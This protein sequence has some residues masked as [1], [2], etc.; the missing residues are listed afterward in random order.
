MSNNLLANIR[1]SAN[2]MTNELNNQI[3]GGINNDAI[4][5]GNRLYSA[6]PASINPVIQPIINNINNATQNLEKTKKQIE[7]EDQAIMDKMNLT[8]KQKQEIEYKKRLLLT[9]DRMLALTYEKNIYKKKIIY[10][11]LALIIFII[12]LML[13]TYSYFQRGLNS[14]VKL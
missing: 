9:R 12:I 6:L 13:F 11:L 1:A 7:E 8:E 2:N 14:N 5:V 3:V 4:T 10:T